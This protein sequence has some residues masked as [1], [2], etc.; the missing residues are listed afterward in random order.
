[1][2]FKTNNSDLVTVKLHV[3]V[4]GNNIHV[5]DFMFEVESTQELVRRGTTIVL[6][7]YSKHQICLLVCYIRL[8][9]IKLSS[10]ESIPLRMTKF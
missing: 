10:R 2:N 6:V 5:E 3:E 9:G 4:Q 1:M 8:I 7:I